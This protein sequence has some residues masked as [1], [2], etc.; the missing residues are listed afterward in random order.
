MDGDE[1]LADLRDDFET[2]LSRLSSSK[3]L[4]AI[5]GGEMD[6]PAIRAAADAEAELTVG[7]LADWAEAESDD[8]AA[9]LFE[10]VRDDIEAYRDD[11]AAEGG[12]ADVDGLTHETLSGF[13]TT[14]ERLG[15]LLA[16]TVIIEELVSQMVGYFV[17]DADPTTANTFRGIRGE[18]EEQRASVL[19]TM[20]AVLEDDDW[21]D[22]RAAAATTIQ[23]GYEYYTETLESM[24]VQP[25]NVC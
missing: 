22:A 9:A 10:T 20:D 11:I 8:D 5:T 1:L 21:D 14:P 12:D 23:G 19:E 18:V 25:K 16:R 3:A 15:G 7:L 4:Y 2:E 6:G 17:G 24:G 13:D